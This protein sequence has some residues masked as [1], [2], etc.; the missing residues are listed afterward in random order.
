MWKLS[1]SVLAWQAKNGIP[2][3]FSFSLSSTF[4][5]PPLA[6]MRR[7][8]YCNTYS[9]RTWL[10]AADLQTEH[11]Y[12]IRGRMSCL[13]RSTPFLMD[14]PLLT[15]GLSSPSFF[16]CPSSCLVDAC[17]PRKLCLK[18]HPQGTAVFRP[19]VRLSENVDAMRSCEINYH[20]AGPTRQRKFSRRSYLFPFRCAQ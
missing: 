9:F 13:R 15:T 19:T 2:D 10:R 17:C 5:G 18:G 12:S 20:V 3:F 1:V 11:A 6:P 8:F 14:R 4:Q 16:G 7:H